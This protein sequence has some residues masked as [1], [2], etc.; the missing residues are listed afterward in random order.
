MAYVEVPKEVKFNIF[1]EHLA[2]EKL[3]ALA[4]KYHVSRAS[5]YLWFN[6][7]NQAIFDSFEPDKRGPK[8][9]KLSP[10]SEVVKL[11]NQVVALKEQLDALLQSSQSIS[12]SQKVQLRSLRP[13]KCQHC[14]CHSIWLHGNYSAKDQSGKTITVY[15][16]RC[17]NCRRRVYPE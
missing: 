7:A 12:L 11:R 5:I 4:R 10:E 9:K 15:R 16:F 1:K 6:T 13:E 2:G 17:R 14:G 3:S 8:F